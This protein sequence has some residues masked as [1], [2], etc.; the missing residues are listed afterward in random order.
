MA[1]KKQTDMVTE[2]SD[3]LT[4]P[5]AE[6]PIEKK[7]TSPF[8]NKMLESSEK[9]FGKKGLHVSK[10]QRIVGIEPYSLALQ[11]LIDLQV[12]PMQSIVCFSGEPKSYKTSAIL[13]FCRMF[14]R[15]I[16]SMIAAAKWE[17]GVAAVVHTEG[18]WSPS[19]V[20]SML[21]S[22]ADDLVVMAA[23]SVEDWQ[24]KTS[25]YLNF[26]KDTIAKKAEARSKKSKTSEYA[27]MRIPA[28]IVG[29]DSLT[30]AQSEN[31]QDTVK[32][33]GHGAKTYQDR[34]MINWQWFGTWGANLVGMPVTII[35]SNH[36]KDAINTNGGPPQKITGGGTGAG[37]GCALEI[38]VKN[39]G[40]IKKTYYEGAKLQ[41]RCHFNSY[42]RDKRKIEIPYIEGYDADDKQTAKYDWDEALIKLLIELS[43]DA[44][45]RDRIEA[46]TGKIT[47]YTKGGFGMV[48]SCERFNIDKER[49]MEDEVSASVL[50]Q[51]LQAPGS[52]IR[53][54]L[55]KALRIQPCEVWTPE[56]E[57]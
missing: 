50:G 51:M 25:T 2:T 45:Y 18:K 41:W 37:F 9:H 31:I 6:T 43:E 5:V 8:L 38:R 33:E 32:S 24:S 1:K 23:N 10:A 14:M 11:W 15:P 26:M 56:T 4:L 46:V 12:I 48:Y 55:Q 3:E 35:I 28:M 7:P 39:I 36:L 44:M 22:L 40:E 57:L 30:G 42:G 34:A 21:G 13:E 20:T 47:E 49:A 16:E 29:I 27:D 19:K 53:K 52:D 54:E 17:P